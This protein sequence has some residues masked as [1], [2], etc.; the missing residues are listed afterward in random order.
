M[1]LVHTLQFI[2]L[3]RTHDNP[4]TLFVLAETLE[5]FSV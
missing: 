5:A 4:F 1:E 2:T 3:T